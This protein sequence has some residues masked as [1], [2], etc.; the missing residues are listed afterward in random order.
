MATE[1]NRLASN[2]T[3]SKNP[4]RWYD[5]VA[6]LY[7][8]AIR[9]VYTRPRR[10]TSQQ[11]RLE[12]GQAV[13]DVA[14]GTG[15]NF[16][17]ILEGIGSAGMLIGTDYSEGMLAQAARKIERNSWPNVRLLRAD[18]RTLSLSGLR[19]ELALPDLRVDRVVCTLGF[20]VIP[21][22]ETA[23]GRTWDLL[24]P[25][26]R[27]AIMDWYAPRRTLFT[28]FANLIAAGDIHRPW[29]EALEQR[30]LEFEC[31]RMFR[32]LVFVVSG[33]KPAP[34]RSADIEVLAS[35]G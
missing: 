20:S 13:L 19:S 8:L 27:Y 30:A 12:A 26:G 5:L 18:A 2:I 3:M 31:E 34:A 23:F 21:D 1:P 28:R 25:G 14:C 9:G 15:E 29:W 22:W 33:S 24:A 32:G 16:K 7:D 11:L 17:H 6:P 35:R 10:A 4:T